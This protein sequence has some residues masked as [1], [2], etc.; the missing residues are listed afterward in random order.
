MTLI[1]LKKDIWWL[2]EEN[3]KN[4]LKSVTQWT[5]LCF[6]RKNMSPTKH[7]RFFFSYHLCLTP[8][9]NTNKSYLSTNIELEH[10]VHAW[11]AYIESFVISHIININA[12]YLLMNPN[13]ITNQ[14]NGLELC[15]NALRIC[16]FLQ[17]MQELNKVL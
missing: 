13:S 9:I 11:N 14:W 2:Y 6:N 17:K 8:T 1:V 12:I 5:F 16:L 7:N 15:W 4:S 10:V 3:Y